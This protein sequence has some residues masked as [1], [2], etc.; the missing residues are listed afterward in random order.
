MEHGRESDRRRRL[1]GIPGSRDGDFPGNILTSHHV[2]GWHGAS[3]LTLDGQ[4][5]TAIFDVPMG[6]L[7]RAF[8]KIPSTHDTQKT[9]P[10]ID[11]PLLNRSHSMHRREPKSILLIIPSNRSHRGQSRDCTSDIQVPRRCG[12]WRCGRRCGGSL[13]QVFQ[14]I[15]PSASL[16]PQWN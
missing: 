8:L 12:I 11:I 13:Y 16:Q 1:R 6:T 2:K 7:V 14:K 4:K 15:L 3:Q 9:T 10:R 5:L